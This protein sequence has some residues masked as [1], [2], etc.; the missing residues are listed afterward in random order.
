MGEP[1]ARAAAVR[2][3]READAVAFVFFVDFNS[4]DT[5]MAGHECVFIH[6][7]EP[8]NDTALA[9]LHD[10]LEVLIFEP[11]FRCRGVC[12]WNPQWK[13]WMARLLRQTFEDFNTLPAGE[14]ARMEI[15]AR[16]GL[17]YDGTIDGSL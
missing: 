5:D 9:R 15:A 2:G 4:A 16:A 14:Y 17:D 1:H 12:I 7:G 11:E 8:N 3:V 13:L 6:P 10:G